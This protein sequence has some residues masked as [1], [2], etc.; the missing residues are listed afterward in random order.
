MVRLRPALQ[1]E[2]VEIRLVRQRPA[3]RVELVEVRMVRLRPALRV[4]LVEVRMVRLLPAL[5][6]ELVEVRMVRLLPALWVQRAEHL[7]QEALV[8]PAALEPSLRLP[9]QPAAHSIQS[10]LRVLGS[11]TRS[12]R[13]ATRDPDPRESSEQGWPEKTFFPQPRERETSVLSWQQLPLG[14]SFLASFRPRC[15]NLVYRS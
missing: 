7:P 5:W 14:T 4:E 12:W 1:V 2:L 13:S 6:V 10:F 8:A 3:L 11:R 9:A 15:R